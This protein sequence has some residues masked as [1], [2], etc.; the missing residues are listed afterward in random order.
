MPHA[1]ESPDSQEDY[2]LDAVPEHARKDLWSLSIVLLGFTFFTATMWGGGRLGAGFS[3]WASLL[4]VIALGNALLGLYVAALGYIAFRTGLNTVL[5]SRYSFGEWGSKWPDLAFGLTQIG[6]YAWGTA[7]SAIILCEL[8]GL[9]GPARTALMVFFG[10]AFCSTAYVGYRGLEKL[11]LVA[12]PLMA[13]LIARSLWQAFGDS[14]SLAAGSTGPASTMTFGAGITL[15]FGTFV[16]GGTQATNWTR[17]ARTGRAAVIA[18]LLAFLAGNGLMVATGAVGARVYQEADIVRVL[19][20]Q[21]LLIWGIVMLLLNIWTTQDNTIYNYSIAGCNFFRTSRRRLLTVAGAVVGTVLA[22]AGMY[23][24][25][26][27]YLILLGTFVPPIGGVLMAD[28]VARRKTGFPPLD[29]AGLPKS[30]PAGIA[31]YLTG[32]L[33]A[34]FSPGVPPVNGI[35]G[36]FVTY[37]AADRLLRRTT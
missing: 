11:S 33:L 8:L 20:R 6:W 32:A 14:G 29:K 28:Y 16:S 4:T 10:L 18:S 7:T 26:L 35:A 25:L 21:G 9:P 37:L 34:Y 31:A 2:P 3:S 5:L 15:V 13:L 23:E 27:P 24:W 30:N 12:V 17:F 36:A 19:A 1:P 22:L